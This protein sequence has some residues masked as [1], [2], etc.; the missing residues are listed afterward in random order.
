M[1][2]YIN[3]IVELAPPTVHLDLMWEEFNRLFCLVEPIVI[4][5]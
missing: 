1:T 3:T 4:N 2:P 5:D